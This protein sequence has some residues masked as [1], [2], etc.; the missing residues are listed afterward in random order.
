MFPQ[1]FDTKV[2]ELHNLYVVSGGLN[3]PGEKGMLRELFLANMIKSVIPPHFGIGTGIVVDWKGKQSPQVDVVIYDK[4]KIPPIL[5]EYGRGI[6]P[7]DSV[8]RVIEVKSHLDKAAMVQFSSLATMFSPINDQGLKIADDGRL[9]GNQSHYPYASLFAYKTD[10]VSVEASKKHLEIPQ[11]TSSCV[12]VVTKG[13]DSINSESI[14]DNMRRFFTIIL[15]TLEV[16]AKSR[17]DFSLIKWLEQP[18]L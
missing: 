17:G 14:E 9:Q 2:R 11:G 15:D 4:R 12:C 7:L 5:E 10:F 3:H 1:I 6:Y 8:L 18:S 16:T 13:V